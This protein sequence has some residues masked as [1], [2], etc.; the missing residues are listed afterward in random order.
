MHCWGACIS[1]SL[2]SQSPAVLGISAFGV[3]LCSR[4]VPRIF[5]DSWDSARA[6]GKWKLRGSQRAETPCSRTACL[7]PQPPALLQHIEL[8]IKNHWNMLISNT[9]FQNYL[10]WM[11][12]SCSNFVML[13]F[14][15]GKENFLTELSAEWKFWL[16]T[17]NSL[18]IW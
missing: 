6:L 8:S 11:F 9:L 7:E 18:S 3:L 12:Q 16:W 15:S 10:C 14:H 2:S 1:K 4:E 5:R 17:R 13:I